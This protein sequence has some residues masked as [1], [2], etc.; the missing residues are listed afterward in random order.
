M[1]SQRRWKEKKKALGD[2]ESQRK[3][4]SG[5]V[6]GKEKGSRRRWKSKKKGLGEGESQPHSL[7]LF[8]SKNLTQAT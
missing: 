5:T 8:T 2:V 3:K 1:V 7:Y 6:E 4:P